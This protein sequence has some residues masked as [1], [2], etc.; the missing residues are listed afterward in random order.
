[1]DEY[2]TNSQIVDSVNESNLNTLGN[3]PAMASGFLDT[4]MT[5]TTGTMLHQAV[6]NQQNAR[7]SGTASFMLACRRILEAT[8]PVEVVAATPRGPVSP[9]DTPAD[10]QF[11]QAQDALERMRMTART[12]ERE[13]ASAREHLRT[14]ADMV[15]ADISQGMTPH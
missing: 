6:A 9:L 7:I 1:M 3:G 5:Q 14:L 10:V 11:R 8:P 2:L 12:S 4:V 15:K 13:A